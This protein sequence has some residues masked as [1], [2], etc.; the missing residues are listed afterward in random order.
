MTE[1]ARQLAAARALAIAGYDRDAVLTHLNRELPSY[2]FSDRSDW[3]RMLHAAAVTLDTLDRLPGQR[4]ADRWQVFQ[5]Q[6]WPQWLAGQ[7]RPPLSDWWMWGARALV[8]SRLVRPAWSFIDGIHTVRWVARLPV[9]DPLSTA[10][11]QLRSASAQVRFGTADYHAMAINRGLRLLLHVGVGELSALTEQ[12]LLTQGR[13]SKGADIL[14]AMLCQ[15]K[16]FDRTPRRGSMRWLTTD[17]HTPTQLA[18]VHGVPEPFREVVGLYLEHYARRHSDCY[19]TLRAKARAL[20]HFF[21]WLRETHTD[22]V[23]CAQITPAQARGFVGHALEHARAVQRGRVKGEDTT[24]AHAWLVDVRG[25]FAD[26]CTWASDEDSPFAEHAPAMVPLTRHDLLDRGFKQARRRSQAR[27]TGIVLDL[28]REIP[29][30]RAFALRRWHETQQTLATNT[31]DPT[32]QHAER[33]AFWDWAFLELLLT[34]GL[35]IEEACELTTFDVLKRHLPDGR[36]YYLLH[37]KPSKFDRARVIPIG[38]QLGRVIAEI[39]R[40]VRAFHGTDHVPACDRRD[41]HEKRSLPRAPYLLQSRTHPCALNTNTIRGRLRALSLAAG[42]RHADGTPLELTP[43]DCRR[44]FASEHLNAHTPVHVIQALLGHATVNTVMIYAKLYP[45]Q[46][47][48]EYRKAMR[49]LYGDVYGPD[50]TRI[51][52]KQ[53]W[54]AFTTSCSLRDMGTHL[55]ALPTGEHCP[56]GLVCLGCQH[57]QPKK[58]AAPTFHRMLTSHTRALERA[59]TAGEPA[60]QLAARELEVERIRNALHRAEELSTDAAAALEAAAV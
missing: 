48:E 13:R 43:H 51:P 32:L 60:G 7:E 20:A 16:V 45:T 12:D 57:A 39:I 49:G 27:M 28:E 3:R 38:D 25:F 55:C 33:I 22:V 21:T 41:E 10:L 50:A 1:R 11:E 19:P 30:I 59:R 29:N 47:V 15:L 17:R 26:I 23:S 42:A 46:L 2:R 54:A 40:H 52:T 35:R 36:V 37:I 5:T 14:D 34:S 6:V 8:C 9:D 18:I 44:V 24:T 56:R 31:T 58:S 53:E 4:L